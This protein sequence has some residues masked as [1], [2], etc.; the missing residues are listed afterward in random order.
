M[1]NKQRV[2]SAKYKSTEST[3]KRRKLLRAQKKTKSHKQKIPERET[4]KTRGF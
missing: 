2:N 3:K 4:Y 1:L